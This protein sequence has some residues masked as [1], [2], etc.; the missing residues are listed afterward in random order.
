MPPLLTW[1]LTFGAQYARE[2]HPDFPQ[3]HPD[4][5]VAIRAQSYEDARVHAFER[6]GP[7]WC[8]LMD[9][10]TWRACAVLFVGGVIDTWDAPPAAVTRPRLVIADELDDEGVLATGEELER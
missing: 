8:D 4:G 2:E 6:V 9:E 7:R 10:G 3:A 1:Y 5:V